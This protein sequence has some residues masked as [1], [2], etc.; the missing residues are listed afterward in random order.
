[1]F[2]MTF[3]GYNGCEVGNNNWARKFE[4]TSYRA[5]IEW[6]GGIY[7]NLWRTTKGTWNYISKRDKLVIID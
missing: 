4:F 2:V 3:C 7:I 5:T 6:F 1:M